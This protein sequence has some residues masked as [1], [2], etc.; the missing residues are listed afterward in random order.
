MGVHGE[1]GRKLK[2]Q[3]TVHHIYSLF[4]LTWQGA[5]TYS[6]LLNKGEGRS[7]NSNLNLVISKYVIKC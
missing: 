6:K 7:V 2:F 4:D 5:T 1:G 3:C